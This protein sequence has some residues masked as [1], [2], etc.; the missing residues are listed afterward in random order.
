MT[1]G[2]NSECTVEDM[3]E[4]LVCET[5]CTNCSLYIGQKGE[6]GQL[7]EVRN[8]QNNEIL[9]DIKKNW[10]ETKSTYIFCLRDESVVIISLVF[11]FH[12]DLFFFLDI[13]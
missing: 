12:F 9:I 7:V 10:E 5:A 3:I 11:F 2:V 4:V 6:N 8:L 1:L 13:L